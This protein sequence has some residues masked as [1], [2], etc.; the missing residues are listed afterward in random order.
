MH[1]TLE[2]RM[3]PAYRARRGDD[4]ASVQDLV[5]SLLEQSVKIWARRE[6]ERSEEAVRKRARQ[7][8]E[9]KRLA[10]EVARSDG[11]TLEL[12][13]RR[14]AALVSSSGGEGEVNS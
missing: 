4:G 1:A 2:E 14:L 9:I 7:Q 8:R 3:L 12:G 10:L 11:K 6:A 5:R 13:A